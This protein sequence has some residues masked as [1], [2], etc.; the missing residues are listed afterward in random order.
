ME[1]TRQNVQ[2][3]EKVVR[4]STGEEGIFDLNWGAFI[5]PFSK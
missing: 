2:R 3:D 5:R 1:L 4:R